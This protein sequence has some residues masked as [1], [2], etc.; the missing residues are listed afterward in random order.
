MAGTQRA[1]T[2]HNRP[3][4]CR[5]V[6]LNTKCLR[7]DVRL[8]NG[9]LQTRCR[10]VVSKRPLTLCERIEPDTLTGECELGLNRPRG[11]G[12][13][14]TVVPGND[15]SSVPEPQYALGCFLITPVAFDD[16]RPVWNHRRVQCLHASAICT[17]ATIWVMAQKADWQGLSQRQC[18]KK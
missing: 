6:S 18:E 5:G 13:M 11:G 8:S 9:A 10:A 4:A 7:P 3:A 12:G 16:C 15:L 2:T 14:F 17:T 1:V